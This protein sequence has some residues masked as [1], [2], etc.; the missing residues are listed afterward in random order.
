[1]SRLLRLVS[2]RSVIIVRAP[3]HSTNS[4][5]PSLINKLKDQK[6]V[7]AFENALA[8]LGPG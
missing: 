2:R 4:F 6:V 7:Q 1:M 5:N 8:L 3:L